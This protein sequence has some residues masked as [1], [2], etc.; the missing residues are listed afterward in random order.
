MIYK[1]DTGDV[2]I[3]PYIRIFFIVFALFIT[4][5]LGKTMTGTFGTDDIVGLLLVEY[6]P[7][8]FWIIILFEA[9]FTK[10]IDRIEINQDLINIKYGNGYVNKTLSFNK[11]DII[12]FNVDIITVNRWYF[13]KGCNKYNTFDTIINVYLKNG[14]EY[15]L[16]D[17]HSGLGI[18]ELLCSV[19]KIIPKFKFVSSIH[20]QQDVDITRELEQVKDYYNQ[21]LNGH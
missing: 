2:K 13:T 20:N 10:Y 1:N 15:I 7:I 16:K 21:L 17:N 19:Y 4:I 12:S 3:L 8:M 14:K 11:N 9:C 18:L 6:V 5:F